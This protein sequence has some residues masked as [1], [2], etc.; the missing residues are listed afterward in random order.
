MEQLVENLKQF[1]ISLENPILQAF[2]GG[3]FTWGLTAIGASLVFFFKSTNRKTL[4]MC[5][6]F[7]GGVMIAASF[8]SLLS[9]AI[10]AVEIQQELGITNLPIWFAPASGFLL[11]ALFLYYLDKKIPHLH[12]FNSL[13]QAEGPKTN[14][15]KLNYLY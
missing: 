1:F 5:L 8:W 11:G 9:P 14:S 10:A 7:T 6:G 15:K 12:L 2:V 3:L 4:D 13:D